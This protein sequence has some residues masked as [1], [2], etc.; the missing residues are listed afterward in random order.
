[1]PHYNIVETNKLT[2]AFDVPA[3]EKIF[4]LKIL[5]KDIWKNGQVEYGYLFCRKL[6]KT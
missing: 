2:F 6:L 1:M 3:A 5:A 4:M